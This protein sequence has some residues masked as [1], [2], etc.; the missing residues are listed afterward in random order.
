MGSQAFYRDNGVALPLHAW[1]DSSAAIGVAGRLGLGKL[2]RLE[3]HALWVQ[4]RLRLKEFRLLRVAGE[5]NPADL[6]TKHLESRAKLDKLVGL[7]ICRFVDGRTESALA[8]R[9]T[10]A[11]VNIAH[12]SSVLLHLHVP[13]DIVELFHEAIAKPARKCESDEAPAEELED[14]VPA[15]VARREAHRQRLT[16]TRAG[17]PR[18]PAPHE[19]HTTRA[20]RATQQR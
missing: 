10:P 20:T 5:A 9:R 1:T 6:F 17:R 19:A 8:L 13:E 14:P 4:Q 7:F 15:I 18:A 12:D 16:A 11:T 2:C 3:C